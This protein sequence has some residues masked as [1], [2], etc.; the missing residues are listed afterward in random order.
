MATTM[1]RD[2]VLKKVKTKESLQRADLQ[3]L[4]LSNAELEGA[5]FRRAD[6]TG[7]NLEGARLRGANLRNASLGEAFLKLFSSLSG[8][9]LLVVSLA[10]LFSSRFLAC[11]IHARKYRLASRFR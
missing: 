4:D 5:D 11:L 3:G 7:A 8:S 10:P 6:L 9:R 2:E 1:T